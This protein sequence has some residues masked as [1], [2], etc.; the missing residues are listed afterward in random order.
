MRIAEAEDAGQLSFEAAF[1]V[2]ATCDG[3]VLSVTLR[4]RGSGERHRKNFD[5]IVNCTGPRL[6]P[7]RST[8]LFVTTL[9]AR[10]YATPHPI[11]IGFRVDDECRAIGAGG[12]ADPH[13]RIVGPLTYGAF[14]DQQGAAFIALRLYRIMPDIVASLRR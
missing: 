8:N 7:D 3:S 9:A 14:A 12:R 6:R 10:G 2:S 5:A 11:G 13:L 1:C 4:R